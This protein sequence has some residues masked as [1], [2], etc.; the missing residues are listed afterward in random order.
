M[1]TT[2]SVTYRYV[3]GPVGGHVGNLSTSGMGAEGQ[4]VC[5][6]DISSDSRWL[7]LTESDL[8]AVRELRSQAPFKDIQLPKLSVVLRIFCLDSRVCSR[9]GNSAPL[10]M[11]QITLSILDNKKCQLLYKWIPPTLSQCSQWS[12]QNF[13]LHCNSDFCSMMSKTAI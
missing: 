5:C 4:T 9:K 6:R 1:K 11:T 2:L 7:Q 8:I 12:L 10:R 3:L 13:F